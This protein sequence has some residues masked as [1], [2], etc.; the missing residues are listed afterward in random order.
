MSGESSITEKKQITH[1]TR[2]L[3][4]ISSSQEG[5]VKEIRSLRTIT[6]KRAGEVNYINAKTA[7]GDT[8]LLAEIGYKQ[9]LDRHFSTVQVFGIAFSIMGLLPSIA[10]ILV[11]AFP[12]GMVSFIW[13]WLISGAFILSIGAAMSEMASAIPTSGG[14]YYYTYYYAP[15]K[16]KSVLSFVIGNSN[17]LALTAALCSIDYGL[18]EEILSI[19][20][21]SRDGDFNITNGKTYGVYA[22]GI[23]AT[24]ILTSFATVAVSKLQTFS[25]ISNL[26]LI[27]FFLIVLPIGVS[28]SDKVNF[29]S[30]KFIFG[31][32]ENES[33]WP[34]GWQF[35][36][37]GFQPAVWVIGAFDSCI[38]MSEEAKNATKAVP[39]GIL[40]SITVCWIVGFCICITIAACMDSNI[41]A[42]LNTAYGQPLAQILYDALGKKWAMAF[43]SLIAFCQFIMGA[44]TLTAISRQIWAFSRDDGLPFSWWI[45]V[46]NK[47]LS[48]PLRA[49]WFG[50]AYALFIGLLCL[51]GGTASNAL[52]SMYIAANYFAWMVPNLLRMTTGR[53]LFTPGAFYLGKF[54][55]PII[56]WISIAFEFF[57]II[58]M[59][60]PSDQYG[61]TPNTMNYTCVF[62]GFVWFGS[63][64]Y[65]L[66]YKYKTFHG[67]KSNIDDEE[68]QDVVSQD[69]IDQILSHQK[70]S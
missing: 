64:I 2:E 19:V 22:A 69:V 63:L 39:I 10:S 3:N 55:S 13:G 38:H 44:S 15:P 51:I 17:T 65:Y 60:F 7:H 21:I 29:N 62:V 68:F 32:W 41:Q 54:W 47:K 1:A 34:N 70:A 16:F 11:M 67:P 46:V 25:I 31:N 4:A 12:G 37:A 52:F 24:M 61:V 42:V 27:V 18:A 59:M 23:V 14:L 58:M 43:M 48:S 49:T 8:E 50:G 20:V 45:K 9:E 28:K 6:S 36:M 33:N 57:I 56:N 35:M 30:G 26:S 40:S 66:V 53:D 5:E